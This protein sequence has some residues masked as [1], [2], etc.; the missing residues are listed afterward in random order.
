[1]RQFTSLRY[2]EQSAIKI[3]FSSLFCNLTH[4]MKNNLIPF[5]CLAFFSF[6]TLADNL[7]EGFAATQKGDYKKATPLLKE[8]ATQGNAMAQVLLGLMYKNGK[9]LKQNTKEAV[10]SFRIA[11]KQGDADGQYNLGVMYDRGLG[12]KQDYK[13]AAKCYQLAAEQGVTDAQIRLGIMLQSGQGLTQNEKDAVKWF[14]N[15]AEQNDADAQLLLGLAYVAGRGIATDQIRG[16]MWM[17]IAA[18]NSS[19]EALKERDNIA[20]KMTAKQIE[21]A[22]NLTAKC[23]TANYKAC[24]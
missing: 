16:Y 23:T 4:R 13:E 2:D 20:A 3:N 21:I 14:R 6:G 19:H 10:N 22:Q 5:L 24:E 7:E 18:A 8:A 9:G 1:M 12:V 17:N 15:A 11:A